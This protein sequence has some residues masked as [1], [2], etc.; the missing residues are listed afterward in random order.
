MRVLPDFPNWSLRRKLLSI[1]MLSCA[2]CLLV[3]LSAMAVSSAV[4]RYR[5]AL[6]DIVGLADVLAEN[7]Q[8]ALVFSDQNEARRLLNS[9]QEHQEIAAAWMV[10]ADGSVLANWNRNSR[11]AAPP[12][13]SR[14]PVRELRTD[15]WRRS[16]ELYAPVIRNTEYV[17]YVL[18]Q[19]D[20]TDHWN[21]QLADL[22]KGL[23]AAALALTLVSLLALRLQ[24]IVSGPVEQLAATARLIAHEQ[25]YALRVP[26]R[27]RDEIGELVDAFNSMLEEIQ[28][29]DQTLTGHRDRLE[30]EVAQRTAELLQAKEL[31]EAASRSKGL[32]LA[33]MSHEIR[34]P[35]NAIIGL[36]D[37]ALNSNPPAKLRDYL[38]KI[39]TSSLALL[40]ITNDILDYSKIEAGRM[41]LI[42]ET[43]NLEEVLENVL[44]LF[45]VRAEEKQLEVVLELDP[46]VP[47]LLEGDALRLSQI[48]NNLVGNAVKFTQRGEIHIKVAL[49]AKQDGLAELLFSVRDTGIGMTAEQVANLFQAFTQADG[50]ITRRFGGT[51]LGL[52]ISKRLVEMMGGDLHVESAIGQG[53]LFEFG[54]RLP[55]AVEKQSRQRPE[56]LAGMRV[57]VVDDLDISRQMLRDILQNWGFE[58]AEAANGADALALLSRANQAGQDFELVLLDWKM[59]GLDGIQV[60]RAI[61]DM[62][63]QA[64][65]RHAPVVIMVTAFSRE[66][67]LH[68]AGDTPPDDVLVKP[69]LP[70]MLLDSVTRLQGGM[71]S[72]AAE[73]SR[74]QLAEMAAPIR[75][76]RILLVEDNEINQM[77]TCEYLTNAGLNVSVANNG[78]EGL[79]AMRRE[80]FDAV[81]M[82]LQMPEMS[83]IEATR[84]IRAEK[85]RDELPII[86]MTAAVQ[87]PDRNQ[88]YAAGMN[89]HVGKPVLPQTLLAALVRCIRPRESQPPTALPPAFAI[90]A[91]PNALPGFDWDYIAAAIAD[92]GKLQLLLDRFAEKFTD[93]DAKLRR[94]LL[95]GELQ[96]G[97]Q[98][99]HYLK[100]AAG[101]IGAAELSGIAGRLEAELLQGTWSSADLEALSGKLAQTLHAIAAYSRPLL[102]TG[103]TE[104]ADWPAAASLTEQ[105]AA[106]L[107][108]SDYVPREIT[109]QLRQAVAGADALRLVQLIEKYVGDINYRQAR[110]TLQ[111]LETTIKRHLP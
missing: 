38:R 4:G 65:I 32:F 2:A 98:W 106:L 26:Q 102:G 57:L 18:M 49:R 108:G 97:A 54:L 3:S 20:F 15:F 93:A 23:A 110:V 69:V 76:A 44:N 103:E 92:A 82:D 35:M 96:P 61:K 7:G 99:L 48:L 55:F 85:S 9:L 74:P 84:L 105:L 79:E 31:A 64:E 104:A 90:G 111:E 24:R 70:S 52:T 30:H 94:H 77:V 56:Q 66:S 101:A 40:A 12:R 16:A 19:A 28:R 27:H 95:A 63:R 17:G 53:S 73:P 83:G 62:V 58:V 25:N 91:G 10:A 13:D 29:R 80:R 60:T 37:L 39:H 72:A 78:R 14:S 6:Q 42:A 11:P 45:I 100:G 51:G 75:G 34:T 86:A 1:I 67:L 43:F 33:N 47:L 81:L 89:D 36:S 107:D 8:A 22:G 21:S 71:P 50:S 5:N 109:E 68:A 46:A 88:C 87:E 41:A 59:P